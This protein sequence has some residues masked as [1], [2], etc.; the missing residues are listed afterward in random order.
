MGS[1]LK[2]IFASK[3]DHLN[4]RGAAG[5]SAGPRR[6]VVLALPAPVDFLE[7]PGAGVGPVAL[8]RGYRDPQHFGRLRIP[9]LQA[10]QHDGDVVHTEK[11]SGPGGEMK[12]EL[13]R[14]PPRTAVLPISGP[15][16]PAFRQDQSVL[17]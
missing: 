7:K 2:A 9:L 5:G 8:G 6:A 14:L 12:L 1:T 13:L 4:G 16:C 17:L 11:L 15:R 10:L 3:K